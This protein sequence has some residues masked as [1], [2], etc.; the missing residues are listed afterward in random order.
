MQAETDKM[1]RELEIKLRQ[2]REHLQVF[3]TVYLTFFLTLQNFTIFSVFFSM[4]IQ[5][6]MK[7]KEDKLRLVKQIL[8]DDS[9]IPS[10]EQVPESTGKVV[11]PDR[12]GRI[13]RK[14][15]SYFIFVL[16]IF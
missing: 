10:K 15:I 2:Q 13:S 12:E 9:I 4:I 5:N 6:Q 3:S 14:V 11:S 8:V 16:N 7:E 1:N